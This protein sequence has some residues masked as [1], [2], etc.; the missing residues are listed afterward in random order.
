MREFSEA[1]ISYSGFNYLHLLDMISRLEQIR[2][3]TSLGLNH[4][5]IQ[6]Q[7]TGLRVNCHL[8]S[9]S[10]LGKLKMFFPREFLI[11]CYYPIFSEC[12][13]STS[14]YLILDNDL[15]SLRSGFSHSGFVCHDCT[16][17]KKHSFTTKCNNCSLCPVG[18]YMYTDENR[19]LEC[20]AGNENKHLFHR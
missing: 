2:S 20:P 13:P 16:T 10:L 17:H 18:T 3:C 6:C 14:L 5:Q 4:F 7:V 9:R 8:I 12:A 1:Y 19:C 11:Y 15:S